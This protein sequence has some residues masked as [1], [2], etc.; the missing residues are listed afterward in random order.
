MKEMQDLYANPYHLSIAV[1]ASQEIAAILARDHDISKD[2][3]VKSLKD[4]KGSKVTTKDDDGFKYLA[5]YTTDMLALARAGKFDDTI[6]RDEEIRRTIQILC[7]RTKNSV[8]LLGEPGVGKTTVAEGLAHRMATN[9]VPQNLK[10]TLYSL[11][12]GAL[13]AGAGKGEYEER[14]KGV[15]DD[16]KRSQESQSPAILFIDELHLISVGKGQG[17]QAGM[18][19]ANLLKPELARGQFRCIGATTLAEYREH[20][21]KDG[22]LTRRFAQVMV[23]EPTIDQAKSILRGSREPYEAHHHVW[24]MDQA[25]VTAVELAHRYLTARRLPDS[26]FDLMDEACASARVQQDLRPEI[27]D[28][29]ESGIIQQDYYIKS[30]ER[31]NH[32]DDESALNHAKQAKVKLTTKLRFLEREQA[33]VTAWWKL[34]AGY[35][36]NIQKK[37]SEIDTAK[38]EGRIDAKKIARLEDE[39]KKLRDNL[40]RKEHEGP[41]VRKSSGVQRDSEFMDHE[42][43][44]LLAKNR[45][46]VL[47]PDIITPESIAAIVEKATKIPVR[48]LLDTDKERLLHLQSTLEKKV[49]GQPEAIDAV[50]NA[51]QLSRTGLGNANRPNACLLFTGPSGTGKTL[52]SKALAEELFGHSTAMIRIDGSEY[53]QSHSVSRLIGAP[54]GYVGYDQGGQLTEYV[55]RTP[56][57]IVLLD[58]IEKA[59]AQFLTLFLQVMDDGRLT[60][61]Q[62]RLVDFRNTAII[63]T[64]NVGANILSKESGKVS[65]RTREA[66]MQR[67][68][69]TGFSPEFLN[70]VDEVVMFRTMSADMMDKVLE[71]HLEDLR[72]RDGLKKMTLDLDRTAKQWLINQGISSEYEKCT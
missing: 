60:D 61:G 41:E 24:I 7:R 25:I 63:M 68:K 59:C 70:R 72:Q 40:V 17:N 62:G 54:P 52:L 49:I 43:V 5:R 29:L 16:V 66:V 50:V 55:R 71:K 47:S 33:A 30:L 39:M 12:L 10:G 13:F 34:I 3:V 31:D 2:D 11:D 58:E 48:Q 51:I 4:L 53:S 27:I 32:P 37:R 28:E 15:I 65:D 36:G 1:V 26:A 18:D 69:D 45:P 42:F 21:E 67:F 46:T 57:C 6:G 44:S 35:R 20:I 64:S 38:S 9:Q 8:V 22:A 23:N 56:Y 19:A 14:V